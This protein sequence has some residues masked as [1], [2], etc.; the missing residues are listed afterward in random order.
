M[1]PYEEQ[2]LC[3]SFDIGS[4]SALTVP[5]RIR[6]RMSL[7]DTL[8]LPGFPAV[9]AELY[10][11]ERLVFVLRGAPAAIGALI[12]GL[13]GRAP[14]G[15]VSMAIAI[16]PLLLHTIAESLRALRRAVAA[17]QAALT[18]AL[19]DLLYHYAAGPGL[20]P[21]R[22]MAGPG[23]GPYTWIWPAERAA[24]TVRRPAPLL[25]WL[26]LRARRHIRR[27]AD[28]AAIPVLHRMLR[29]RPAAATLLTLGECH[30]RCG[31]PT[32]ALAIWLD[33]IHR[34]P[35]VAEA[36]L[37]A[38]RLA[39][40]A[41]QAAALLGEG[42]RLVQL[43]PADRLRHDLLLE[44]AALS[45]RQDDRAT[46][47]I[48]VNEAALARPASPRPLV[49]LAHEAGREG[50]LA[51]AH[52]LLAAALARTGPESLQDFHTEVCNTAISM[53]GGDVILDALLG[54]GLNPA[55]YR[56]AMAARRAN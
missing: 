39:G 15:P 56:R 26:G 31:E 25:P 17:R 46:G 52:R 20:P 48:L 42:L 7:A 47:D 6:L 41:E 8:R 49:L 40:P 19:T 1:M 37:R 2:L 10:S 16:G 18:V 23:F 29:R 12:R 24:R 14:D 44:L 27:G 43:N 51:A 9:V 35:L 3:V 5:E 32:A 50:D 21:F 53:P 45:Y 30:L 55:A 22:R 11:G 38:G 34:R 36:Y 4:W 13:A 54:S 33:L 28:R